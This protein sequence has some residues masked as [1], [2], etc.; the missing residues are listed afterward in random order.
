M[1]NNKRIGPHRRRRRGHIVNV[2]VNTV[3]IVIKLSSYKIIITSLRRLRRRE[4]IS[5]IK[6]IN[7]IIFIHI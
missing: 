7:K 1:N 4:D 6:L 3:I 2:S 5:Y